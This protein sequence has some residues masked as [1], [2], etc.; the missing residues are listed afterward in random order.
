MENITYENATKE[1]AVIIEKIESGT[2]SMSEV[3]SLIERAK[4][5]M[6]FCYKELDKTKGKLTE[7]KETLDSLEEV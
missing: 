1:L 6:I 7:I 4:E 5:L 3:L 2:L